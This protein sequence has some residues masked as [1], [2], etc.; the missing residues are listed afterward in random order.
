MFMRYQAD[1]A[2][3]FI[4]M[5]QTVLPLPAL[6]GGGKSGQHRAPYSGKPEA[7]CRPGSTAPEQSLNQLGSSV[8]ARPGDRQCRRK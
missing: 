4:D 5:P 7:P 1:R 8:P 3:K 6:A 2:T